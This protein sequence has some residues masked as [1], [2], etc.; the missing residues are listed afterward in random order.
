MRKFLKE[1]REDS[2]QRTSVKAWTRNQGKS[3]KMR[4]ESF[5]GGRL[6]K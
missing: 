5:G 1:G 3:R 6:A 2:K 4:L